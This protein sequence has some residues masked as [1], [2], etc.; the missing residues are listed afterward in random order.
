MLFSTVPLCHL[1]TE[2]ITPWSSA[3]KEMC[4]GHGSEL[5]HIFPNIARDTAS[6]SFRG[7]PESEIDNIEQPDN[8]LFFSLQL[9]HFR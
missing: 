9:D 3:F 2:A 1:Q 5:D 4:V 6:D 8:N 7:Y